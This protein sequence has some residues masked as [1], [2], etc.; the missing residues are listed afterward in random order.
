MFG[1][2]HPDAID[3]MNR[4]MVKAR[5]EFVGSQFVKGCLFA[6]EPKREVVEP[7]AIERAIIGTSRLLGRVTWKELRIRTTVANPCMYNDSEYNG[8]IKRLIQRGELKSD[9]AGNRI[10]DGAW[11]WPP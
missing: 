5:R 1:S 7:A 9:C 2:R 11:V 10:E 3:L 6:N 4:G 8:A